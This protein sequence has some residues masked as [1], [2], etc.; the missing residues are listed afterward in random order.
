MERFI[1]TDIESVELFFNIFISGTELLSYLGT[2][3]CM[4][5][6]TF[7]S[8]VVGGLLPGHSSLPLCNSENTDTD[9]KGIS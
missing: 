4:K 5:L 8:C 2:M 6:E 1:G 9:Q 3:F 7:V